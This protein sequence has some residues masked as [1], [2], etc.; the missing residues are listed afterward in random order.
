MK[1]KT[2]GAGT[3]RE[4][5]QPIMQLCLYNRVEQESLQHNSKDLLHKTMGS[6][7][8]KV[9]EVTFGSVHLGLTPV[10]SVQ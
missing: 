1:D 7:Q 4:S 9:R 8:T 10:K 3:G 5:L 6:P 2:L